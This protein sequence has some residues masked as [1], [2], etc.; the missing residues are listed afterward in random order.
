MPT[1]VLNGAFVGLIYGLLAVG[2]VVTYRT[3]RII[4]FA[5]G[6]T[7][8]L[9]AFAYFDMRLGSNTSTFT[10]HHGG[11]PA[12]PAA[13]ALGDRV[14]PVRRSTVG[15]QHQRDLDGDVG[16]RGSAVGVVGGAHRPAR[17][18]QRLLHDAAGAAGVR[19]RARRRA[20]QHLGRVPRRSPVGR[21]RR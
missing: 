18:R 16:H 10:H 3:A 17:R 21:V 9:A 15:R 1:V 13:P 5:Y 8:M 12:P 14:E 2:L 19:G 6:E 11:P 4:N 20:H 7:G